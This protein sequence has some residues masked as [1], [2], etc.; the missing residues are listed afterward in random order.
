MSLPPG[1]GRPVVVV[2]GYMATAASAGQLT[3]WLADANYEVS[4]ASVGRNALAS[5]QAVTSIL[6]AVDAMPRSGVLIGHSRGGQQCRVA[7]R[8]RPELIDQLITLGAPVRTHI[9]R[10]VVLRTIVESWR[11]VGRAGFGPA[12]DFETEK[13]YASELAAPFE[14]DVPWTSIWSKVDGIVEWQAC[15]DSAATSI[16]VATSHT[17]LMASTESFEAIAGVLAGH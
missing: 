16:E 7:A 13:Q 2:T 3:G 10:Q 8:R 14:V 5:E 1:N 15:I 4:V 17:G 11:L 9:P 12:A 6:E